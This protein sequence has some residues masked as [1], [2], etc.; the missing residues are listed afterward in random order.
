MADQ[1]VVVELRVD[2]SNAQAGAAQYSA[3]L[4]KA[5][6]TADAMTASATKMQAAITSQGNAMAQAKAA[7]DNL[8][9]TYSV[10]NDNVKRFGSSLVD[11]TSSVLNTINHLKLLALAIYAGSPAFR[12]LVNS[13]VPA[14]L[15]LIGNAAKNAGNEFAKIDQ[16]FTKYLISL[17]LIDAASL[18]AQQNTGVLA[19]FGS[20]IGTA[21]ANF[22][23]NILSFFSRI[24]VPI[25]AAV[26]AWK[27]FNYVVGV[28][29]DLLD[30]Y[31]NSERSL[32]GSDVQENL[33]KLTKFQGDTVSLQQVQIA[34]DLGIRLKD[35]KKTISDFFQVQ[36]DLTSPALGL[37]SIW[38][39]IVEQIAKAVDLANKLH[40]PNSNFNLGDQDLSGAGLSI[41]AAPASGPKG[42]FDTASI[43]TAVKLARAKLAA[44]MGGG[45]TGRFSQ[46]INSLAGV[47]NTAPDHSTNGYDRQLQTIKDQIDLLNQEAEGVGKTSQAYQELKIS[48]E[49]TISAM[50]AGIP[51]TDAMRTEWKSLADQIAD[52][53]IRVNQMKVLLGEQF[54]G[55]TMF[56]S[57]GDLAAANA[58]HQIDPTDWVAHLHDAGPQL[59][60]FNANLSQTRDL[61]ADFANNFGQ[62]MLQGKTAIE[63]LQSA[64]QNLESQLLQMATKQLVNQ[65]FGA[66]APSGTSGFNL[67]SMLFG[68]TGAPLGHGGIGH[69]ALGK[70]FNPSGV[71]PF[72]NGGIVSSPTL[73]RFANGTGLMG[74]A[75]PEAIMPLS[76]GSDGRLGVV[77]SVAGNSVM[78][79]PNVTINNYGADVQQSTD[80][81]GNMEITVRAITRDEMASSRTNAI[82]KQKYGQTPTLRQRRS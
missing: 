31:G 54:K 28:G 2:A 49:L 73:F 79:R 46:D 70:V 65:A 13:G 42:D 20:K 59:A 57:P 53:T 19:Q 66:L 24:A 52:A 8:A 82:N 32:F 3:A 21:S 4:S 81:H 44:G 75:G 62:A 23:L 14:A 33:D 38:V 78:L 16:A 34:T 80:Q 60:A 12:T 27:S 25:A 61:S 50:K 43:Y 41:S 72:A 37:Q 64:L 7:N 67:F 36:F 68:S 58:A 30:K 47:K 9:S 56:M 10:A 69:A 29:S 63:A 77:S 26:L 51:I 5:Q 48:H 1:Y 55:A 76:R 6:A 40:L 11:T 18:K 35:A 45:F 17:G 22:G 15:M 74:E 71:M 39:G